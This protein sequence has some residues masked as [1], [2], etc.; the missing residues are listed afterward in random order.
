VYRRIEVC[1]PVFDEQIKQEIT[2]IINFQLTDNVQ[3]VRLNEAME[4]VPVKVTAPLVQSQLE[5][6]HYLSNKA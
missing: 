1:F 5:V 3:A 4:N 6:Y 2:D